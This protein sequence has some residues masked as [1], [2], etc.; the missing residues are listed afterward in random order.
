VE[1]GLRLEAFGCRPIRRLDLGVPS[2][3]RVGIS[4]PSGAGKSLFLRAVA[5]LDPHEGEMWLDGVA[6]VR[7]PAPQW[8]RKVALLPS[9]S[10]WWYDTVGE[11]F[12]GQPPDG[13]AQLGFGSEVLGWQVAHLSSGER[14][15][16]AL[17]RALVNQPRVLLLDEPTANLDATNTRRVEAL[18]DRYCEAHHPAVVWVGHDLDQ[19][20]RCCETV[21][22]LDHGRLTLFE[23]GAARA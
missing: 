9:E 6:S 16:L 7:M 18:V 23:A 3:K 11:H 15:R 4:G 1:T 12:D 22:I 2:G 19:L 21:Y 13:L 8:R 5:D 10:A 14:Q 17:L 20:K